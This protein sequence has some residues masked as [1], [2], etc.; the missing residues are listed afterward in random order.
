LKV[1]ALK[2]RGPCRRHLRFSVNPAAGYGYPKGE[3]EIGPAI[4]ADPQIKSKNMQILETSLYY[5]DVQANILYQIWPGGTTMEAFVGSYCCQCFRLFSISGL[6]VVCGILRR[7]T[8][9]MIQ[10]RS[11][12]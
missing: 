1:A 6:I 3:R 8:P 2:E 4:K 5:K 7:E 9:C 11:S 10:F 12:F